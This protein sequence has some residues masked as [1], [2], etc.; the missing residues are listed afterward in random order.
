MIE[1]VNNFDHDLF[2]FNKEIFKVFYS[3]SLRAGAN[4]AFGQRVQCE[5][6]N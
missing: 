4:N 1:M 2:E 5:T 3:F 6:K